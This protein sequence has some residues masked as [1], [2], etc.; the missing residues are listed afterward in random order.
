MAAPP[1]RMAA[2]HA[3]ES[4]RIEALVAARTAENR[5][6]EALVAAGVWPIKDPEQPASLVPHKDV[7]S[8]M[9]LVVDWL[10]G[11]FWSSSSKPEPS[12]RFSM[13]S[14][15]EGECTE[16]TLPQFLER[17][18]CPLLELGIS[19]ELRQASFDELEAY[20]RSRPELS[21]YTLT[22]ELT[23]MEI[24]V[25]MEDGRHVTE[26]AAV[27]AV[28]DASGGEAGSCELLWRMANQSL[29]ADL[30]V[31]VRHVWMDPSLGSCVR[32]SSC[33]MALAL[34][35]RTLCCECELRLAVA[36]QGALL[37]VAC[38]EAR[39]TLS[40]ADRSVVY[41]LGVPRMCVQ[42]DGSALVG[43]G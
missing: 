14:W 3:A 23:R 19:R 11:V 32:T 12:H 6:I 20:Y 43:Q 16:R 30:L 40:L 31:R 34:A 22:T 4:R 8:K 7:E 35:K 26:P 37:E 9:R 38:C 36:F 25:V 15:L 1:A 17:L 5:R 13:T 21:A 41:E 39:I 42:P 10:R 33:K 27:R 28:Y 18:S 24:A 2:W 29:V